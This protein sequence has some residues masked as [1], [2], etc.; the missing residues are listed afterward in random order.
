MFAIG[1]TVSDAYE[2]MAFPD[3]D[4]MRFLLAGHLCEADGEGPIIIYFRDGAPEHAGSWREGAVVS[5]W[6]FG[7]THIWQH[8]LW[9]VPTSY[10]DEA[11]FFKSLPNVFEL[12]RS[13]VREFRC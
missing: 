10:G 2:V 3:K 11:R 6:G 9:D 12:Y 5:K 4:F 1:I 7:R 13:W 8:A